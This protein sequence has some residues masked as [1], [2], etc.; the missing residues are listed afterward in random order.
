MLVASA[1]M[2]RILMMRIEKR[3]LIVVLHDINEAVT[4]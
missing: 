2:E 1:R 4:L 3:I